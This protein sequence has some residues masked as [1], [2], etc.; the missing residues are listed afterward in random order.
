MGTAHR[1]N[2]YVER[3]AD[4]NVHS[5]NGTS[6]GKVVLCADNHVSVAASCCPRPVCKAFSG[7][8]KDSSWRR[9][10]YVFVSTLEVLHGVNKSVL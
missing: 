7:T 10:L 3:R 1:G 4:S 9:R 2:R 6:L 5:Q 8:V